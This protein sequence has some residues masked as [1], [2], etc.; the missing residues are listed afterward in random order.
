MRG[1]MPKPLKT[2]IIRIKFK[3]RRL[4]KAEIKE[5]V[6]SILLDSAILQDYTNFKII[7]GEK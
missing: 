1:K 5:M 2:Y 6:K 7:N 3:T 4:S